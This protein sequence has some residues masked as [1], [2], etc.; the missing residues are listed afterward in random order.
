MPASI[1]GRDAGADEDEGAV[2]LTAVADIRP[3]SSSIT[4]PQTRSCWIPCSISWPFD[5]WI[6]TMGEVRAPSSELSTRCGT[7][8]RM[9]V[10]IRLVRIAALAVALAAAL[11][12]GA[13]RTE[14]G[15]GAVQRRRGNRGWQR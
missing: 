2:G 5:R 6:F 11:D 15:R 3:L 1:S 12:H 8:T 9:K 10:G 7:F 4:A 13:Q 14:H